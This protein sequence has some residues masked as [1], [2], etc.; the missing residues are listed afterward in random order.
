[1][2]T[3]VG[4]PD[5]Y[6][7]GLSKNIASVNDTGELAVRLGSP[8]NLDRTGKVIY[9]TTF[10][11]RANINTVTAG[12]INVGPKIN[13]RRFL[14][15][16]SSYYAQLATGLANAIAISYKGRVWKNT[17]LSVEAGFLTSEIP[18]YVYL[19]L[20][21]RVGAIQYNYIVRWHQTVPALEILVPPGVYVP[22]ATTTA[23]YSTNNLW[24]HIKLDVDATLNQY[25]RFRFN[26]DI[27]DLSTYVPNTAVAAEPDSIECGITV[28]NHILN[29]NDVYYDY[30]IITED[31]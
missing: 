3:G 19:Q 7:S 6:L 27:Y 28:Y 23:Y 5:W 9:V 12:V 1:M 30:L 8:V 26:G 14:Y 2:S 4:R 10:P 22:F 18:S 31:E 15:G 20:V 17:L 21:V 25:V 11:T 24:N 13:A 16:C 29:N